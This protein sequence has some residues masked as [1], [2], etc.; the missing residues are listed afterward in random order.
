MDEELKNEIAMLRKAIARLSDRMENMEQ[1]QRASGRQQNAAARPSTE[2]RTSPSDDRFKPHE[3][4]PGAAPAKPESRFEKPPRSEVP[5][6]DN[7][8]LSSKTKPEAEKLP[9]PETTAPQV[10]PPPAIPSLGR[11]FGP[12]AIPPPPVIEP[13]RPPEPLKPAVEKQVPPPLLDT[14]QPP[15]P[16]IRPVPAHVPEKKTQPPLE[17]PAPPRPEPAREEKPHRDIELNIGQ[18][19]LNKIG[20]GIF[21][22]GVGFLVAY[23]SK[24]FGHLGPWGKVVTGLL[25]S[26]GM[27][28]AGH[29]CKRNENMVNYGHVLTGGG[30]ALAYFTVF[31]MHNFPQSRVIQS[32]AL[33]LLLLAAVAAGMLAH[34]L[35]YRS[36][37]LAGVA[38]FVGYATATIGD[39]RYFTMLSCAVES[40][41]ILVL[42]YKFKWLRMLFMGILLTYGAH[43]L[44][45]FR[46]IHAAAGVDPLTAARDIFLLNA[47]FLTLY[48]AFFTAGVHLL[49]KRG[50][51]ALEGRLSV[52]NIANTLFYFLLLYPDITRLFPDQ[53]FNFVVGLGAAFLVLGA[54][55]Y[56]S[57]GGRPFGFAQDRLFACD[58]MLGIG[59]ISAAFPIKYLPNQTALIWLAELPLLCYA[60]LELKSRTIRLAGFLMFVWSMLYYAL[61][62]A[63]SG[64]AA[65]L[66]GL[67]SVPI[68][69]FTAF[70][71]ALSFCGTFTLLRRA[72]A[73]G[74]ITEFENVFVNLYPPAAA[75]FLLKGTFT[76]AAPE[77][78]TLYV[79]L[80]ALLLFAWGF[81]AKERN[82][83]IYSVAFLALGIARFIGVDDYNVFSAARRWAYVGWEILSAYA[84]YFLYRGMRERKLLDDLESVLV[85][86]V[87]AGAGVMVLT[88]VFRYVPEYWITFAFSGLSLAI[89]S[90][91]Y[92]TDSRSLRATAL[93][94]SALVAWRF[95]LVDDYPAASFADWVIIA[96]TPACQ[97]LI[98]LLY[99]QLRAD[100]KLPEAEQKFPDAA[101]LL[102]QAVLMALV[103]KYLSDWHIT[104]GFAVMELGLFAVGCLLNNKLVRC[105]SMA[106]LPFVLWRFTFVDYYPPGGRAWPLILVLGSYYAL[107]YAYIKA[108]AGRILDEDERPLS[109]AVF[110]AVAFLSA[111]AIL[112]Y[113]PDNWAAAILSLVG[114]AALIAGWLKDSA[115]LRVAGGAFLFTALFR[116]A[117]WDDYSPMGAALR[118]LPPFVQLFSF[119]A[120]YGFYRDLRVRGKLPP[121]EADFSQSLAA[122]FAALAAVSIVRYCPQYWASSSLAVFA[123]ALFFAGLAL[124]EPVV[125]VCASSL[126]IFVLVRAAAFAEPYADLGKI[127]WLPIGVQLAALLGVY[128]PYRKLTGADTAAKPEA[129]VPPAVYAA[130]IFLLIFLVG[131]YAGTDHRALIFTGWYLA[132]FVGG[133]LV[134]DTLMRASWLALAPVALLVY[135]VQM[136]DFAGRFAEF[137][138]AAAISGG[139]Y[140]VYGLSKSSI[141]EELSAVEAKLLPALCLAA[142]AALVVSV[143]HYAAGHYKTAAASLCLL[144]LY[145]AGAGL[146][147]DILAL[148][149]FLFAPYIFMR[150][151]GN[152]D[153]SGAGR[154]LKWIGVLSAPAAFL[155]VHLEG[156]RRPRRV[157]TE[158]DP[159]YLILG[160]IIPAL[161]LLF[162]AFFNYAPYSWITLL[163]G[164]SGLLFFAPG[165]RFRDKPLRYAGL[166][167]FAAAVLRIGVVDIAGL[168]IIYKI[169]SFILLGLILLGV[170]Y[171]YN[172]FNLEEIVG[173]QFAPEPERP[174]EDGR[175]GSRDKNDRG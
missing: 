73:A 137:A 33:D 114:L 164:V 18:Y 75:A 51:E 15:P 72:F 12:P 92:L 151:L 172:R 27:F 91:A 59:L 175:P 113:A 21:V 28:F 133:A 13:P 9:K 142:G 103:L 43:F 10:P 67:G 115:G 56:S 111:A 149:A 88:A 109:Y 125:R 31:A 32:Q 40:L 70:A 112:R 101:Y 90:V 34:S 74:K 99:G 81:L 136:P 100:G 25:V 26:A 48:W 8:F 107:A 93:A 76:A 38:I 102:F 144:G 97:A 55:L 166:L 71:M 122:G 126:F 7:V 58:A 41:V 167:M 44:W 36:E 5:A 132:L 169:I 54:F 39:V 22:L 86:A 123:A 104:A 139:L 131:N 83:R 173:K 60:G 37:A 85:T 47:T 157:F 95:I 77:N 6:G 158:L 150:R 35:K 165:F 152:E 84:I 134:K 110:G 128:L 118:W 138:Y 156:L 140:L 68:T 145:L 45:V 61:Y 147:D 14:P 143:D 42:V 65:E 141:Q 79:F 117:L 130:F 127:R 146:K 161:L 160:G 129:V 121:A 3:Q 78:L 162:H 80:D 29:K 124:K 30:W 159:Q 119:A 87:A 23:S 174:E 1:K 16:P 52:A 57:G 106:A 82:V 63:G 153:Y 17:V 46:N 155:G 2:L 11:T 96:F 170:S 148:S 171:I 108:L 89:F 98:G 94:G 62:V 19:W 116:A 135:A 69:A 24:Y 4:A 105:A 20:I 163:L 50:D 154:L 168:A 64:G 53:R 66:A 49:R 120:G